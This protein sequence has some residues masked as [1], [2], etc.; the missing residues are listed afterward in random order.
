MYNISQTHFFVSQKQASDVCGLPVWNMTYN[1]DGLAQDC[2]NSS[3][4]VSN[5]VTEVL[6]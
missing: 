1:I 2:S 6:S 4:N 3:A 5:G